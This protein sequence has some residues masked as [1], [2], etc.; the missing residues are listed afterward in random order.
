LI[1]FLHGYPDSWSESQVLQVSHVNSSYFLINLP[2][3]SIIQH[4][5]NWKL[6]FMIVVFFFL[7]YIGLSWSYNPGHEFCELTKLTQFFFI[8]IEHICLQFHPSILDWLRIELYNFFHFAFYIVISISWPGFGRLTRVDS[9]YFLL[10]FY[11]IFFFNLVLKYWVDWELGFMIFL[12]C[13]L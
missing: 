3:N 1:C 2:L 5:F 13:F 9:S 6:S 8:L 12:I 7:L 10:C 11:L 4:C